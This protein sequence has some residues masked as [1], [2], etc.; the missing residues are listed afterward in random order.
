[1]KSYEHEEARKALR[2]NKLDS[3]IL[4]QEDGSWAMSLMNPSKEISVVELPS[5]DTPIMGGTCAPDETCQDCGEH[6]DHC[7]CGYCDQFDEDCTGCPHQ[8]ECDADDGLPWNKDNL[9]YGE[10]DE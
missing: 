10:D 8:E 5:I 2:E 1:M 9:E 7:E 3:A 4:L 6:I